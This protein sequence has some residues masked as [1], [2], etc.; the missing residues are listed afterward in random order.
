MNKIVGKA[1]ERMKQFGYKV[2]I[3]SI[4]HLPEVQEATGKLV[5]QGL[6]NRRLYETWR[7]SRAGRSPRACSVTLP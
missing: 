7:S 4:K 5:R 2:K 3:V 1:L 6:L